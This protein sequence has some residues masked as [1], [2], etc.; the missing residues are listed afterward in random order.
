MDAAAFRGLMDDLSEPAGEFF[1]DNYISNETSYLQVSRQLADRAASSDRRGVYIGV[2]PEQNF[3]YIALTRPTMAYIVDIRRDNLVLQLLYKAA[4]DI[5]T[6]RGHFIALLTARPHDASAPTPRGPVDAIFAHA[7]RAKATAESF[8]QT[9][10]LLLDRIV[11]TYGI[12][13]DATDRRS[14]NN[15]HK[16]FWR[17]GL[18]IRFK[19]KENSTRKYPTLRELLAAKDQHGHAN[20]FFASA[21]AFAIVQRMQ[22][23]N[24]IVPVVGDFAGDHALPKLAEHLRNSGEVVDYF[25][26]SNVEQYLMGD[27][28]WWKWQRN[29]AAL[30]I[31]SQSAFIRCYLDQG[32]RH[33]QQMKGHRTATTI[34]HIANFNAR[35]K[36]YRSFHALAS[37]HIVASD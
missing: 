10:A 19:L 31:D 23:E 2:G 16:A 8:E 21:E 17:D 36:R 33:R 35:K 3:T 7:G 18:D 22:R 6:D 9:H 24:R 34:H 4:F 14:L 27:G 30:P 12:E 5:A 26:V 20:G 1:S 29:I 28:V 11:K 13:L 32:K 37:D 25:Y 15:A